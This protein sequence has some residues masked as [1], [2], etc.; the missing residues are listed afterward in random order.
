MPKFRVID[1]YKESVDVVVE[2]DNEEDAGFAADVVLAHLT[3]EE[4]D[5]RSTGREYEDRFIEEAGDE[6]KAE[7]AYR[8]TKS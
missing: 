8:R 4:F 2:V 7:V 3:D 1:Y 6:E 5:K